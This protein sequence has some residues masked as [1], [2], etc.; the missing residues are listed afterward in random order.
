[1][2]IY[3][4]KSRSEIE[5][6]IRNFFK[7]YSSKEFLPSIELPVNDLLVRGGKRLRPLIAKLSCDFF[8][9]GRSYPDDMILIPELV[10]N[11]SLIVDDIEDSS[12]LRRGKPAV[13]KK[14]G[15][16]I[17][18]N[19]GTAIYFL[20]K[21][22]IYKSS[23]YFWKKYRLIKHMDDA[24]L[25]IH[26]GQALDIYWSENRSY[27]ISIKDYLQMSSFKTGALLGFSL[28]IGAILAGKDRDVISRLDMLG[29]DIGISFQIKDD[30]LN[31]DKK[32]SL[33]KSYAEDITEGKRT[34]MVIYTLNKANDD[35]K[36]RLLSILNSNTNKKSDI[37]KAIEIMNKYSAIEEAEKFANILIER[38]KK[39]IGDIVHK[40]KYR[41]LFLEMLDDILNRKK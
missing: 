4:E 41:K 27:N 30:I 24:L 12:D 17:S 20:S 14:F 28:K 18:V 40:K 29:K 26:L 19:A 34:F 33:G 15:V 8:M 38:S 37:D 11:G 25:K 32:K 36:K 2:S 3:F 22:I 39:S 10:H 13:H 7:K 9:G 5:E 21:K 16:P 35:D 31:L 23:M 1:M 6:S